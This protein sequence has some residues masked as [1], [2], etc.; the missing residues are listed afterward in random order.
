MATDSWQERRSNR[1]WGLTALVPTGTA[2]VAVYNA[3]AVKSDVLL[4]CALVL[5]AVSVVVGALKL[6]WWRHVRAGSSRE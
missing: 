3:V 5:L 4:G 1:R 2:A 6:Y